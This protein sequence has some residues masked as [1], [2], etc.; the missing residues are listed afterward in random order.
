MKNG[1]CPK[2][3]TGLLLNPI[4]RG[5]GPQT[6]LPSPNKLQLRVAHPLGEPKLDWVLSAYRRFQRFGQDR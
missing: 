1:N 4:R 3:V 5:C 6:C 2:G